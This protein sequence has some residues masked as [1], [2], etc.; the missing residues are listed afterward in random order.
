MQKLNCP[1]GK[2]GTWEK[3]RLLLWGLTLLCPALVKDTKLLEVYR[4]LQNMNVQGNSVTFGHCSTVDGATMWY[5]AKKKR[6]CSYVE[7]RE[8]PLVQQQLHHP[9][10]HNTDV[11]HWEHSSG[12]ICI[13][14]KHHWL[15]EAMPGELFSSMRDNVKHQ[16]IMAK[17]CILNTY[18]SA[19]DADE[20]LYVFIPVH[21]MTDVWH[22]DFSCI[23]SDL[24]HPVLLFCRCTCHCSAGIS[25]FY[26]VCKSIDRL[27]GSYRGYILTVKHCNELHWHNER[28][29]IT[30]KR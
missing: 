29:C 13:C 19:T 2:G 22:W 14:I 18:I 16:Q 27:D 23:W 17:S 11:W 25:S 4:H 12:C 26:V 15:Y 24:L 1:T 8:S 30:A 6:K 3:L 28:G 21:P 5:L 9:L 7:R 10:N 20:I